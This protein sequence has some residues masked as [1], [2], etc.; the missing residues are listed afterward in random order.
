MMKTLKEVCGDAGGFMF[1]L[2]VTEVLKV[3][4]PATT[5]FGIGMDA[6]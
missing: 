6:R 4:G 2:A 3:S 1:V 5:F